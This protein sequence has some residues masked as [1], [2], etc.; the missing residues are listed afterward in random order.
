MFYLVYLCNIVVGKSKFACH[1]QYLNLL[2]L[3]NMAIKSNKSKVNLSF[4]E[5][6][7][8]ILSRISKS[9]KIQIEKQNLK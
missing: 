5:R 6:G 8:L 2:Y 7:H 4:T 9:L 3:K 1:I